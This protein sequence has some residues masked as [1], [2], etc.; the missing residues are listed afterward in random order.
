MYNIQSGIPYRIIHACA[1]FPF[2]GWIAPLYLLPQKGTAQKNAKTALLLAAGV[3]AVYLLLVI[4]DFF[5]PP[6][7]ILF[8]FVINIVLYAVL[9]MYFAVL[10][11][12]VVFSQ[13]DRELPLPII[14]ETAA[15][16]N[17]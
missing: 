12:G 2:V 5:I 1:F 11:A 10:V 4:V 7:A 9:I 8:S 17:I 13:L 6:T 3:T 14:R 16:L 15:S